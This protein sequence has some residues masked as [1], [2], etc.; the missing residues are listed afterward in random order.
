MNTPQYITCCV[1]LHIN[2]YSNRNQPTSG[3]HF[4]LKFLLFSIIVLVYVDAY[5]YRCQCTSVYNKY[6]NDEY[7]IVSTAIN[8][9]RFVTV[10]SIVQFL[11]KLK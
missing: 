3:F 2:T 11:S 9:I 1:H 4:Y 7:Q 10:I 5:C 6:C 8:V